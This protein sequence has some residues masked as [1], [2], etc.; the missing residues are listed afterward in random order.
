M[1]RD[2]GYSRGGENV[3]SPRPLMR[4]S[5]GPDVV[6]ETA[7]SGAPSSSKSPTAIVVGPLPVWYCTPAP[8]EPS[9][10]PRKTET[11]EWN[12]WETTR[13]GMPSA[14]RSARATHDDS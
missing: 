12:S 3:P 13:S 9:P 1:P 14:L 7:R 8:K 2:V 5:V 10:R 4:V 11:Y 6:V